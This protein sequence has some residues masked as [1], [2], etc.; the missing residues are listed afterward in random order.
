MWF[1]HEP[2]YGFEMFKTEAEARTSALEA[3][4]LERAE[5]RGSG[6]WRDDEVLG[7][8]WGKVIEKATITKREPAPPESELD[9]YVDYGLK[10]I[11]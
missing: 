2:E 3:L 7:I 9:E 4:E 6:E 10:D 11:S 5:A 8:C 1:S